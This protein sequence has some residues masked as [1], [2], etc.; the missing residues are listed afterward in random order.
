[1]R[2]FQKLADEYSEMWAHLTGRDGQTNYEHSIRCGHLSYYFSQY[3]NLY[4]YSQQ[5]FEAMMAKIKCIYHRCTSRGGAGAEV[6]SHILQI[7]HFLIRSMLW[8][9]GHGDMYFNKKYSDSATADET[10]DLFLN[11]NY[12]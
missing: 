2:K 4:K 1:M 8:N 3:G 10:C 5:G 11:D 12:I 7:C 6:R 9:S